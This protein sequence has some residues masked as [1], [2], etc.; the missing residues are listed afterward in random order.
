[1]FSTSHII[2]Q[3]RS[4]AGVAPTFLSHAG[5]LVATAAQLAPYQCYHSICF[6][7]LVTYAVLE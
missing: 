3:P 2:Y 7:I 1:M 4:V 5:R 6:D